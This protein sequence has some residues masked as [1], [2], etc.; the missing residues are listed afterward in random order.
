MALVI[1]TSILQISRI[2]KV[3]LVGI[4]VGKMGNLG[5]KRGQNNLFYGIFLKNVEKKFQY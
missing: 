5:Q 2:Q 1:N 4:K 3:E